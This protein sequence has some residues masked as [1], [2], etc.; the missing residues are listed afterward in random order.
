M[1][2]VTGTPFYRAPEMFEGGGYD[3]MVDMWALGITMFQLMTGQ[4]PFESQYPSETIANIMKAEFS[5][6]AQA[7]AKYSRSARNLVTRL[8]KKR[9]E[10]LTAKQAIKDLWFSEFYKGENELTRSLTFNQKHGCPFTSSIL[11]N[12]SSLGANNKIKK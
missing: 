11:F 4:T 7:E 10:R 8:L 1:L 5:F 2:T 12:N 9:N 3:E 6:P